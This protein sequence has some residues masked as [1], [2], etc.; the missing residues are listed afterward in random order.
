ME[1]TPP[2]KK[3][4]SC[5]GKS[6]G[7]VCCSRSLGSVCCSKSLAYVCCSRSLHIV[8]CSRSLGSVYFGKS[9][10]SSI[11]VD[12]WVVSSAVDSWV[13]SIAVDSSPCWQLHPLV[14]Y[15]NWVWEAWESGL[16][17][18]QTAH[19]VRGLHLSQVRQRGITPPCLPSDNPVAS[20]WRQ[21]LCLQHKLLA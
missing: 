14:V 20:C 21:K 18:Y 16:C 11:V 6:L 7:S 5:W 13:V 12:P 8:C 9:L 17:N 15:P 10:D 3:R 1:E 2:N 19:V 4:S